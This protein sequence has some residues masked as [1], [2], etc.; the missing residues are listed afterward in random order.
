MD[1]SNYTFFHKTPANIRFNDIDMLGHVNNT[2]YGNFFDAA[3]FDYFRHV[4]KID[5]FR[6]EQ[7]VVL[8]TMTV[9]YLHPIFLDD[10]LIIDTKVTRIGSKSF[11]MAQQILVVKDDGEKIVT[12]TTSVL[13]CYNI[14]EETT[15]YL[16][17]EWKERIKDYEKDLFAKE[18]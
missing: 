8:A 9:D 7:W 3:R 13:V 14:L 5:K 17:E 4:M 12:T 11:D 15:C 2:V 18:S 10:K 6:D 16:P 1:F